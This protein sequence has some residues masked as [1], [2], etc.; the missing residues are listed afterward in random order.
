MEQDQKGYW[1][2]QE[3]SE[4]SKGESIFKLESTFLRSLEL[5]PASNKNAETLCEGMGM[6]GIKLCKKQ[7]KKKNGAIWNVGKIVP[8]CKYF[9]SLDI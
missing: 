9:R 7:G 8:Y 6:Y 5:S 3:K 1:N 2:N 4:R